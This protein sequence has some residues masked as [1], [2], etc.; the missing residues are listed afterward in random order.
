MAQVILQAPESDQEHGDGPVGLEKVEEQRRRQDDD[1]QEEHHPVRGRV[2]VS[3]IAQSHERND[4]VRNGWR[5]GPS[6]RG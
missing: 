3:G 6:S 1:A 5:I 2:Q 4:H